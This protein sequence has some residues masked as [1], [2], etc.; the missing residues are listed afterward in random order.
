[1]GDYDDL[2]EIPFSCDDIDFICVT[3]NKNIKSN[4]WTVEYIDD[5]CG[6]ININRKYKMQPFLYFEYDECMYIDG[7]ILLKKDPNILFDVYLK[8]HSIAIPKHPFRDC[9]YQEANICANSGK[10]S[11]SEIDH[12]IEYIKHDNYPSGYGLYENNIIIRRNVNDVNDVMVNWYDL[13]NRYA[14]RDQL[15]LAY[16]CWKRNIII[17]PIMH[18]PRFSNEFFEIHFHNKEKK[19]SFYKKLFLYMK[20]NQSRNCMF[21]Y[22]VCIVDYLKKLC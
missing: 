4:S 21:K 7:N 12:L 8:D 20:I 16:L 15:S 5:D 1:M 9:I 18:G 17:N 11:K 19:L 22:L 10:A 3:N 2:N 6:N 13:F 14:K